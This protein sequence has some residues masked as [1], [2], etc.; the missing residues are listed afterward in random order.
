MFLSL[1]PPPA[2]VFLFRN[3]LFFSVHENDCI[4]ITGT[5]RE[6]SIP[7]YESASTCNVIHNA[8]KILM[9]AGVL[10]ETEV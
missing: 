10:K 8:T 6:K 9:N 3:Y 1:H 7:V 5:H 4:H 2:E